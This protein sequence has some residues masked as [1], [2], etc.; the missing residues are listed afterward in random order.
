[1]N[2]TYSADEHIAP[3]FTPT[4]PVG[5]LAPVCEVS[6]ALP[7]T[8]HMDLYAVQAASTVMGPAASACT[9]AAAY[10]SSGVGAISSGVGAISTDGGNIA[11]EQALSDD[12]IQRQE[13][14][15]RDL[16]LALA[17]DDDVSLVFHAHRVGVRCFLFRHTLTPH[18]CRVR[19]MGTRSMILLHLMT[20][21]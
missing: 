7:V 20:Q 18:T 19:E 14:H 6:V 11:V 13:Q 17:D 8:L 10:V 2:C 9:N 5:G 4:A 12:D 16:E 1:M 3:G 15:I 21:T